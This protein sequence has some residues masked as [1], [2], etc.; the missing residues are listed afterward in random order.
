MQYVYS[1]IFL[2]RNLYKSPYFSIYTHDKGFALW[3]TAPWPI[4]AN[5][6]M[7]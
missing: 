5:S 4:F 6:F 2:I 3:A 1:K 7:W